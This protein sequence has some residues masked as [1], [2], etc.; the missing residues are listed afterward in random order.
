MAAAFDPQGRGA[1]VNNS[2]G[3]I[4]AHSLKPYKDRFGPARW[5]EAVEA[6]TDDMIAQLRAETPAGKLSVKAIRSFLSSLGEQPGLKGRREFAKFFRAEEDLRFALGGLGTVGGVDEIHLPAR[7]VV[8][9]D[10]AGGGVA[11]VGRADHLADDT[12][13]L[14]A[15]GDQGHDG[16]RS[17]EGFQAGIPG[18]GDMLGIVAFGQLGRHAHHFHGDDVQPFFFKAGDNPAGQAALHAVGFQQDQCSFHE[19]RSSTGDARVE[20][21]PGF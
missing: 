18:L 19:H 5:Q 1:I 9:A 10:R 15:F 14:R 13:R 11:A 21:E 6:A 8:A 20:L 4:F 16:T 3:I 2:R 17:D 7:A 12:D